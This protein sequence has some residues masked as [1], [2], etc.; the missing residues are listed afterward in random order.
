VLAS[1]DTFFYYAAGK[2]PSPSLRTVWVY[3]KGAAW[4]LQP[5]PPELWA[6]SKELEAGLRDQDPQVRARAYDALV[7]RPD[8]RS[9]D[10]VLAA[11]RD[12]RERHDGVRQ[13]I[14]TAAMQRGMQMPPEVL[15]DLARGD[16]SESLRLIA[17]DALSDETLLKIVAQSA[18]TDPSEAIRE[19]AA[20]IIGGLNAAAQRS[21]SSQPNPENQP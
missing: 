21:N 4:A 9:R 7:A 3:P 14:L 6:G 19:R 1:Y 8:P 20:R 12:G 18:L 16:S 13:S 15:A 17:L 11:L 5:V 2:E 10:L